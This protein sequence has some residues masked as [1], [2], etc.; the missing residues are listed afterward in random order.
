MNYNYAEIK[1]DEL[2]KLNKWHVILLHNYALQSIVPLFT[3]LKHYYILI[4]Q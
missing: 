4:L 1:H 3:L 2:Q